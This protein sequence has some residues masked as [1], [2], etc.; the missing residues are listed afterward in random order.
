M[1][2]KAKTIESPNFSANEEEEEE[3]EDV[4]DEEGEEEGARFCYGD[5]WEW[6][7]P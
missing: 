6:P 3:E 2:R 4:E 7:W 1:Q 5:S